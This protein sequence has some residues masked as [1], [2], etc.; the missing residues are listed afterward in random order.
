MCR[1][2]F[3]GEIFITMLRILSGMD[4]GEV[5]EEEE[6]V[7]DLYLSTI[8]TISSVTTS[9]GMENYSLYFRVAK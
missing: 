7:F 2:T 1:A 9:P 5:E 6:E 4:S 8:S 3:D